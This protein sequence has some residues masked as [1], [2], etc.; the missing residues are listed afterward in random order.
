MVGKIEEKVTDLGRFSKVK[1]T[2]KLDFVEGMQW[3]TALC[4]KTQGMN[5]K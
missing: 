2:A 1:S 4:Q 3:E 5:L